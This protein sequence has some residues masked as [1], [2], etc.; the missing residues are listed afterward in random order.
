MLM[1]EASRNAKA[2]DKSNGWFPVAGYSKMLE[3]VDALMKFAST[4]EYEKFLEW[5]RD[6]QN[7]EQL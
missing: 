7:F 5:K 2:D 3:L 4:K 6:V 1:K